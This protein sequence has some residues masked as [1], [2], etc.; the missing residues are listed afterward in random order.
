M[1]RSAGPEDAVS[2][3]AIYNHY[4]A[5]TAITFEEERVTA[6]EMAARIRRVESF[7]LPWLVA[8]DEGQV[9]GYAYATQWHYRSAYRYT[10]EITVYL[11]QACC[12]QGWGSK[13]LAEL[14]SRLGAAS[15]HSVIGVIA[16]PN[17]ASIALHEKFG[18]KKVGHFK[19]V[20]F[21]LD[22]WVDVGYWQASLE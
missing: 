15:I 8:E 13:L 11:Q 10:V 21:K 1:I 16:L 17:A 12:A 2:I 9:L 18:M 22:R 19:E 5:N 4:V 6:K 7:N 14:L 3:A 20:G